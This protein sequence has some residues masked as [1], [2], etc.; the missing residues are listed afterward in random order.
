MSTAAAAGPAG[1]DPLA[2]V[3][4]VLN[5]FRTQAAQGAGAVRAVTDRIRSAATSTG[6]IRASLAQGS[7]AVGRVKSGADTAARS[8]ARLGQSA[9]TAGR[10][11]KGFGDR[12]RSAGRSVGLLRA[13]LA[14]V[15]TLLVGIA[16][17]MGVVGDL[18]GA[19]GLAMT[20]GAGVVM[21]INLLTRANP[22][23]FVVGLLL[24]VAGWLID[25]AVNS[26]AGQRFIEQLATIVLQYVQGYLAVITPVL[27]FVGNLVS[28]YFG[29]IL[30]V[31]T[32]VL[33]VVGAVIGTGFAVLRAL[34]TG[35]I[36]ALRQRVDTVWRG[37]KG[38]LE[39]AANWIT[40]TVPDMFQRIKGAMSSTLGGI[41]RFLG[42]GVEMVAG[43]VKAPIN[44]LIA[45]ANWIIDGLNS[46]S[47]SILG[48][49]F[50]I[51]IP[52]IPM[53]AEGGVAVPGIAGRAGRVLPLTALERQRALA[54]RH[55]APSASPYRMAEFRE[56]AGAG[57]RATAE[58]LLFLSSAHAHP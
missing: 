47:V 45:F 37:F 55:R 19:F 54:S 27:Q 14:T 52:K 42:T 57:P 28:T 35:D 43:L 44:G 23:G 34:T 56:S 48:K 13:G 26:E 31:I 50:G 21:V 30:T 40:Q 58:D 7:Q 10:S 6:G 2:P 9:A 33:S 5:A 3:L 20:I 36:E 51:N 41:G 4:P 24:P 39:S 46:L 22:I 17:T 49:T 8:V 11:V 12:A 15:A 1:A 16:G 53:L 38:V 25:L 18:M 29:S 32:T